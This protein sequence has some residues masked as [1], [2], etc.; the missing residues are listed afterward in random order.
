MEN[1][2]WD[3]YDFGYDYGFLDGAAFAI[4]RLSIIH[5]KKMSISI[6]TSILVST[7]IAIGMTKVIKYIKNENKLT[8]V[9]Y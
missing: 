4:K 3:G 1:E 7:G 8:K 6:L 2:F 5:K 9:L